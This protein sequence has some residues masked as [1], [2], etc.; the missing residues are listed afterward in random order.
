MAP[1]AIRGWERHRAAGRW[2]DAAGDDVRSSRAA[3]VGDEPDGDPDRRAGAAAGGEARAGVPGR[4]APGDPAP[5]LGGEAAGGCGAPGDVR[6]RVSGRVLDGAGFTSRAGA[7]SGRGDSSTGSPA[8]EAVLDDAGLR[9]GK[10]PPADAGPGAGG[11]GADARRDGGARAGAGVRFA[12]A[13][14]GRGGGDL[15]ADEAGHAKDMALAES[16][17]GTFDAFARAVLRRRPEDVRVLVCSD[18]GNVEDL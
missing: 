18:H 15:L 1:V 2:A 7:G 8:A 14:A 9:G 16:A 5:R 6:E 13:D 3:P 17:L 11:R 10:G 12:A 4:G